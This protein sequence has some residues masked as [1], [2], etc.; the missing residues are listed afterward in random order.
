MLF[1]SGRSA[2][3]HQMN[4][5]SMEAATPGGRPFR[6]NMRVFE[7][8]DVIH[9]LRS[10]VKRAG[11]QAAWAKEVGVDRVI[12]LLNGKRSPTKNI[13]SAL[14][15]RTIFVRIKLSNAKKAPRHA[16]NFDNGIQTES[17]ISSGV[18][19]FR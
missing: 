15:L 17:V 18:F 16:N 2:P 9:L 3:R 11:G 13:I 5:A 1:H 8:D 6:C 19:R 7:I 4:D 10:E 14:K 12:V